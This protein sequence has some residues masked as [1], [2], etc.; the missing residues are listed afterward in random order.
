VRVRGNEELTM[1][2]SIF[3]YSFLALVPIS[4]L[5]SQPSFVPA[6]TGLI[7]LFT[8]NQKDYN[9]MILKLRRSRRSDSYYDVYINPLVYSYSVYSYTA[10]WDRNSHAPGLVA[11]R[12]LH[13]ISFQVSSWMDGA[14]TK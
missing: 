4:V 7:V 2:R 1:C 14:F 3:V 12:L 13:N 5:M 8:L 9:S 6:P 11:H 10:C